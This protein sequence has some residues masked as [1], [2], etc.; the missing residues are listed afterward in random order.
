MIR[1][2][3]TFFCESFTFD[4][5]RAVLSC[6]YRFDADMRFT[7]EIDFSGI[8]PSGVRPT[9]PG[10]LAFALSLALGMSYYKLSPTAEIVVESGHLSP[11]QCA[12]WTRF[13]RDGL[14]EFLYKNQIPP[15]GLFRFRSTSDT[16]HARVEET[17]ERQA[18]IPIGGGKDSLVS[19]ELWRHTDI[20]YTLFTFGRASEVHADTAR[21]AGGD[22][23]RVTRTIDP[24]LFAMT[25]QGYYNGHVPITGIIAFVL[26]CSAHLTRTRYL[27]L[28]N[29]RSANEG[30][31]LWHGMTV[32]HQHSK[33]IEFERD[34]GGYLREYVHTD[35]R[36][37]SLLRSMYEIRIARE[38]ARYPQYFSV[39]SS[40][41]R[42]F[43]IRGDRPTSR[44]CGICPKCAFVFAMLFPFIGYPRTPEIFG[45]D[46]F[47]DTTLLPLFAELTGI[48]EHKP[49]ECVGT[50]EE[51]RLGLTLAYH[52]E[53]RC[54]R[55]GTL[56]HHSP[57]MAWFAEHFAG[58]IAAPSP[59]ESLLLDVVWEDTCVPEEI[60]V[61]MERVLS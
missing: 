60:R 61:V 56:P 2:F 45:G 26:A 12:F 37:F 46:L 22:Y 10:S 30:N 41:N 18:F 4:T 34:F 44:W 13:Y 35:I 15:E 58:D 17:L 49:F 1:R 39:F 31:T 55:A 3:S 5:D 59:E 52:E 43:H 38:F 23:L 42:N 8:L 6:T 50:A 53:E 11:E 25:E 32:N 57:I 40:C 47:E 28:S 21:V 48:S 24:R 9:L 51:T 27:V 54:I 7:E 19:V 33:G 29:E 20:P 14:G 16:V 36:Y